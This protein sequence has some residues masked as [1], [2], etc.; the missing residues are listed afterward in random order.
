MFLLIRLLILLFLSEKLE[1]HPHPTHPTQHSPQLD[2]LVDQNHRRCSPDFME[3]RGPSRRWAGF[4]I[5]V[6][7]KRKSCL[8][9]HN[10]KPSET[11]S[12]RPTPGED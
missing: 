3:L 1:K 7:H 2:L 8:S 5:Q 9:L 11:C 10:A 4:S 6:V 12:W